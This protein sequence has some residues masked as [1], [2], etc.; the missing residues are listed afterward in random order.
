MMRKLAVMI[1][2][3][4]AA[5]MLAGPRASAQF[6][7]EAFQQSYNDDDGTHK[8]SVD[9]M[10]S[11]PEFLGGLRH[12]REA[13]IGTVFAGSTLFVGAQQIYNKQYWKLP[14]AYGSILGAAGAGLYFNRTGHADAA[15]Y[16]F[17]GAGLAYWATLMDGV[18]NYKPDPYPY[19]G[20]ATIFSI[21]L[22]GLGQAYNGE[23]WK[24]PI[25]DG[26]LVACAYF[27]MNNTINFERFRR[28]YIEAN[29][30]DYAGPI[31]AS[32]AL[33]YRNIYRTYRD[34]SIVATLLVYL[35]QV[36]DANVFAYMHDF[37]VTD[38][39][40]LNL[41]PTLLTPDMQ[42]ASLG[43]A[44]KFGIPTATLGGVPAFGMKL[45]M[46]F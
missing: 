7:N 22:P 10:F 36:I 39:V 8:D 13:R 4:A 21:L 9:V 32:T 28:I 24:I 29:E 1:A 5:L 18:I 38:D 37:E 16:C 44:P 15:K 3:A 30:P 34:Y 25:Y 41:S 23:Y 27:Y 46:N 33:Y 17:I 19:A 35:I 14:I 11:F 43:G 6:K 45:S 40:S 31:Q 2:M 20:K 12:E 26:G 42:M